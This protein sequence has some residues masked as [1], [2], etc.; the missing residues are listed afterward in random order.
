MKFFS[1]GKLKGKL[2]VFSMPMSLKQEMVY[3]RVLLTLGIALT[4]PWGARVIKCFLLKYVTIT[5]LPQQPETLPYHHALS[6]HESVQLE[7]T[8]PLS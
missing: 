3:H 4:S 2:T 7:L 8:Q 5:L 6:A 1:L